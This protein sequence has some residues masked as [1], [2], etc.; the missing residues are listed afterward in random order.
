M[1]QLEWNISFP[2]E[3]RT[4]PIFLAFRY[5]YTKK[6]AAVALNDRLYSTNSAF[7][8]SL[9]PLDEVVLAEMYPNLISGYFYR[10]KLANLLLYDVS[11]AE[12]DLGTLYKLT[13][14][15]CK[16][17][18]NR[19]SSD[20]AG[21]ALGLRTGEKA[22]F[23]AFSGKEIRSWTLHVAFRVIHS[24]NIYSRAVEEHFPV[25]SLYSEDQRS[26]AKLA[27][28]QPPDADA[29]LNLTSSMDGEASI[30]L[31]S[32][33]PDMLSWT[34]VTV[35]FKINQRVA[36]DGTSVYEAE[37]CFF[38]NLTLFSCD[39]TKLI[40][41]IVSPRFNLLLLGDVAQEEQEL[42]HPPALYWEIDELSLW[43]RVLDVAELREICN[44]AVR[45]SDSLF[46][47]CRF[48]HWVDGSTVLVEWPKDT[49]FYV[50]PC[51]VDPSR[52]GQVLSTLRSSSVVSVGRIPG[53]VQLPGVSSRIADT[54]NLTWTLID[55]PPSCT[56]DGKMRF[57][58]LDY[59]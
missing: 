8:N 40:G 1:H 13:Q 27:V 36:V 54:G 23:E 52:S 14:N 32:R 43:S 25:A 2:I 48:D 38:V 44:G 56:Y 59:T 51:S 10:G 21:F 9:V 29:F 15:L 58:C 47:Y 30:Y 34:W 24:S 22:A 5:S 18:V 3:Q 6:R 41:K 53:V 4:A 50:A 16:E 26:C 12:L 17:S 7:S 39:T 57:V 37:A 42:A 49:H 33:V 28:V 46:F 11:L 55:G 19:L 31:S 20:P 35:T 45:G